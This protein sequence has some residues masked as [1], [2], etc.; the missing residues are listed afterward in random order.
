MFFF[1]HLVYGVDTLI[2]SLD[3]SSA[4]VSINIFYFVVLNEDPKEA[5]DLWALL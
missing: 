3:L 1:I 4:V 5:V 2:K